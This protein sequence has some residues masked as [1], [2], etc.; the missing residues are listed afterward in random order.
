MVVGGAK[1]GK[2]EG[3]GNKKHAAAAR[4]HRRKWILVTLVSVL[5]VIAGA[6]IWIGSG[7]W[8]GLVSMLF[9]GGGIVVGV[10]ELFGAESLFAQFLL[11]L[12]ALSLGAACAY[13]FWMGL[14]G[15]DLSYRLNGHTFMMIIAGIG[16]L[17]FGGGGILM[18]ISL[19]LPRKSK[20][21]RS[22][23]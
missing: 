22:A 23:E 15:E 13:M 8:V 3:M 9:F 14:S 11:A 21:S 19:L 4:K 17:F 7:E 6:F 20:R 2:L 10:M 1:P 16:A 5:F 12:A 18:M